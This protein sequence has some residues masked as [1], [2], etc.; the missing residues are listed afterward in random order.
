MPKEES[1]TPAQKKSAAA[2]A[3]A[4]AEN[5][6]LEMVWSDHLER[7]IAQLRKEEE[8]YEYA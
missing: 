8:E 6:P 2:K 1:L 4:E 3:E 5:A 7:D